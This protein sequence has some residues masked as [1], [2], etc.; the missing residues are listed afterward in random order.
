[1]TFERAQFGT[2]LEIPKAKGAIIGAGECAQTIWKGFYWPNVAS[3]TLEDPRLVA[4]LKVPQAKY[5][6]VTAGERLASVREHSY[7]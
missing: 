2:R 1:M 7:R 6:V 5:I 3:M 4:G